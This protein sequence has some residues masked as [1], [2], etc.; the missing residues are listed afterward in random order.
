M[1]QIVPML[2]F[3]SIRF[4]SFFGDKKKSY[5]KVQHRAASLSPTG[6]TLG[7]SW[8]YYSVLTTYYLGRYLAYYYCY[9]AIDLLFRLLP[10]LLS[11]SFL[12]PGSQEKKTEQPQDPWAI[13][14]FFFFLTIWSKD[15]SVQEKKKEKF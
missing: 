4:V 3:Y 9:D 1:C 5:L 2:R 7:I 15:T 8:E 11:F 12:A 14:F 13:P 10:L 6:S